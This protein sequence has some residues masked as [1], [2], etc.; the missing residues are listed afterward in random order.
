M[1]RPAPLAADGQRPREA[2]PRAA[3]CRESLQTSVFAGAA[4]KITRP[5]IQQQP[6]EQ[7]RSG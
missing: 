5:G 6:R 1:G 4:G 7:R 3:V 2:E